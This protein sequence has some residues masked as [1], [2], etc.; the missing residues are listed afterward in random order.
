SI[1]T[2]MVAHRRVPD[3]NPRDRNPSPGVYYEGNFWDVEELRRAIR[4]SISTYGP[5]GILL[6]G[7]HAFRFAAELK[8]VGLPVWLDLHGTLDEIWEYGKPDPISRL[9]QVVRVLQ[10]KRAEIRSLRCAN[11]S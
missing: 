10:Y 8:Q 3:W 11:G 4:R 1:E 2:V 9:K 5:R 6:S 7:R